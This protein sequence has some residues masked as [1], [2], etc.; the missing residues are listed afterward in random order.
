MKKTKVGINGFGRIGRV[1]TRL[2][3]DHPELELVAINDLTPT[4]Q[5]VQLLKYDSV[6]GRWPHEVVGDKNAMSVDGKTLKVFNYKDPSEI[7][8]KDLGVELVFESTG[9]FTNYEG[10]SKHFKGGAKKVIVSAPVKDDDKIRTF[11]MGVN[12]EQYDPAKDDVVSNASCTTNCLAPVVKVLNDKFKITRGLM[13]TVHS[14]TNDQRVLDLG[15]SD[16]RRMRAAALN[17]IPTSTGAAKAV[18]LVIPELKGKLT[19]LSVR[20]PTPN[21]SLVDFVADVEHA[22]TVQEVN[23]VLEAAANAGPLKGFLSVIHE[24]LVSSDFNGS[25]YSSSVDLLSTMVVDRTMVKVLSWYDNETG[26]SS[27]MIDLATWIAKHSR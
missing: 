24:P 6:H 22:T 23:Q 3:W 10:A 1:T 14:Y 19:G 17:M 20:V 5:N 18:G 12:H 8:W 11:V 27:R 9:I 7:P 21:V 4:E 2:L 26:F 25:K 15:H 16:P 13:T